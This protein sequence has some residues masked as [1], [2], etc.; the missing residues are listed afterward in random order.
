MKRLLLIGVALGLVFTALPAASQEEDVVGMMIH[1]K[2]KAGMT[3]Q[4]VQG[5][6]KHMEYH[7][8]KGD[9]WQWEVHQISS[10]ENTGDFTIGTFEH[11]WSDF[12]NIP[13]SGLEDAADWKKN[14]GPYT[15]SMETS[16]IVELPTH[17]VTPPKGTPPAKL[18][19]VVKVYA[20]PEKSEEYVNAVGKLPAAI[21]KA[22][23]D[24]Q[25]YFSRVVTAGRHPVFLVWWVHKSWASIGRPRGLPEMLDDTYGRTESNAIM[26][27]L[28]KTSFYSTNFTILT[29]REDLSYR[30]SIP[31]LD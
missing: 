15:E 10:G 5:A 3:D 14:A 28:S 4:W 17:S 29:Y 20:K 22:D 11:K 2:P 9:P 1:V 13:V 25:Y 16:Y 23:S 18:A 30:P 12:D 21:A 7:R 6:K 24:L 31:S 27:V 19:M 26:D 8:K